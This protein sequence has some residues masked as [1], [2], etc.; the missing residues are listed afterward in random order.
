[1]FRPGHVDIF[2]GGNTALSDFRCE[3]PK[4]A[5]GYEIVFFSLKNKQRGLE[6][7][8]ATVSQIPAHLYGG[9][10]P[11]IGW[12]TGLEKLFFFSQVVVPY[13]FRFG[14]AGAGLEGVGSVVRFLT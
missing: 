3:F 7:F 5:D 8:P 14:G 10:Q 12:C 9:L 6:I 1:M 4:C 2:A 13:K 11:A